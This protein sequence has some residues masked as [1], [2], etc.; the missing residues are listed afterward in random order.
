LRIKG[1]SMFSA[2]F[3][4]KGSLRYCGKILVTWDVK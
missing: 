1:K 2:N 3:F 4:F